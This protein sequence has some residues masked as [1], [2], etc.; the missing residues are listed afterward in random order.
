MPSTLP[1]LAAAV[2]LA[3]AQADDATGRR[4][5]ALR[6]S[7]LGDKLAESAGRPFQ[8]VLSAD[9]HLLAATS[10]LPP[11]HKEDHHDHDQG[12]GGGHHHGKKHAK[13]LSAS[14]GRDPRPPKIA[15]C[16]NSDPRQLFKAL[17]GTSS[18]C[19]R[20]RC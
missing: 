7:G 6:G 13:C 8:I 12:G 18:R 11:P 17:K 20:T 4:S 14:F 2:L 9:A 16:D 3:A 1:L 10:P 15:Q 5:L 19:R